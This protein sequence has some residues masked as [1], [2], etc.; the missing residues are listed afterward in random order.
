MIHWPWSEE[1]GLAGVPRGGRAE[2]RRTHLGN[3]HVGPRIAL[4]QAFGLTR[5]AGRLAAGVG[6]EI[7][8][9]ALAETANLTA[10]VLAAR[11]VSGRQNEG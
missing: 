4:P 8:G 6:I 2:R 5:L 11:I 7:L 1:R 9:A 3:G 10:T